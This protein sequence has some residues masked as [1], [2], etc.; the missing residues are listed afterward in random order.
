[1]LNNYQDEVTFIHTGWEDEKVNKQE[2]QARVWQRLNESRNTALKPEKNKLGNFN[3]LKIAV[4]LLIALS[5]SLIFFNR[6]LDKVSSSSFVARVEHQSIHSDENKAILTLSNGSTITLTGAKN[7]KLITQNGIQISQAKD[8]MLEYKFN[9][10]KRSI[11]DTGDNTIATPRGGQYQVVLS[12]GTKVWLN[13]ASSL[14]F[15]V[16]FTGS[17]RKVELTG[18]AYF[19][20]AK[21]KKKPFILNANGTNVQVLGTHF[22]V[23]AY[24]DDAAVTTT[25]LEGSVRLVRAETIAILKPGE[26]GTSLNNQTTI[27]VEKADIEQVIAWKNGYFL[28]DNTDIHTIMKQAARW[29]D[30]DV[31]YQGSV[32]KYYGGKISKY[33]DINELLKNLELTGT[34]H[35]KVEGRRV[36][37]IQ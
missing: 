8:G 1:M 25:L 36:T 14:R 16:T 2:V 17:Y 29:Y 33:K 19:E 37:V 23:S 10:D 4:V 34:I 20:V 35:F 32:N 11:N 6:K 24:A 12:D 22:N 27:K 21:N 31:V 26:Q 13:A 9:S 15:P 18:E 5:A 7:G 3:V 30:V 28:F